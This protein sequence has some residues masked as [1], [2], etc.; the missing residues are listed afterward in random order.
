MAHLPPKQTRGLLGFE[1]D[2]LQSALVV[3][4]AEGLRDEIKGE[5]FV[6]DVDVGSSMQRVKARFESRGHFAPLQTT[7]FP[8]VE[9]FLATDPAEF[10]AAVEHLPSMQPIGANNGRL[11]LPSLSVLP[12]FAFSF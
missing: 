7:G 6:V 11:I 2:K 9:L 4:V 8:V 3:V 12:V 1:G 5:G 10:D